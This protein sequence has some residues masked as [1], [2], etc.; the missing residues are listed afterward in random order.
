MGL[1]KTGVQG[2]PGS[3]LEL[4]FGIDCDQCAAGIRVGSRNIIGRSLWEGKREKFAILLRECIQPGAKIV[5][6]VDPGE[7]GLAAFVI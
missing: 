2:E 1:T 4:V 5:S 3:G 7:R 6:C